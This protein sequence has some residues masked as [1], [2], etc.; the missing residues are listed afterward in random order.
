M[1]GIIPVIW[2][3]E[4]QIEDA[5]RV[6][7]MDTAVCA[8]CGDGATEWD[9]FRPLVVAQMPTGYISEIHN[10]VPACGKCNQSKGNKNWRDW[11]LSGAPLSP[12]TKGVTDI[13]ARVA[14]LESF[15][16]W[17]TPT[18]VDFTALIGA[19]LWATHWENHKAILDL[20]RQAEVTAEAIRQRVAESHSVVEPPVPVSTD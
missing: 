14:R 17:G 13:E 7:G 10:L 8:Y 3:S 18:Q 15:E 6:L 11:M 16:L 19:D 5:L 4:A 20:M 2:P 9:H 1:N 12:T